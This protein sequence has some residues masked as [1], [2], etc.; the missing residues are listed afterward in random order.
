VRWQ[1]TKFRLHLEQKASVLCRKGKVPT[2][3]RYQRIKNV[4]NLLLTKVNSKY[5]VRSFFMYI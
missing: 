5:S 3:T 1:I 2:V 4:L